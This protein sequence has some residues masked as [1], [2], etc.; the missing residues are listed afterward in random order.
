[1]VDKSRKNHLFN[2]GILKHRMPCTF[3]DYKTL[4]IRRGVNIDNTT[5]LSKQYS[6]FPD[7]NEKVN[8]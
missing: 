3:D 7:E 5:T 4:F 6:P 2:F 1:M 8:T